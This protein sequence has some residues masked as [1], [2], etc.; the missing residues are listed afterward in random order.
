MGAGETM[1][2]R[3]EWEGP[4]RRSTGLVGDFGMGAVRVSLL[5]GFAAGG[6]ALILTPLVGEQ[7]E[8]MAYSSYQSYSNRVDPM[9]TGA[10]ARG[11]GEQYHGSSYVVRRS[12]LQSAPA[13]VCVL[14]SNGALVGDC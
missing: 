6:L 7:V 9:T 10:V 3:N 4:Q 5:F 14:R 13:S 12:V 1:S 11:A 8:R 2:L